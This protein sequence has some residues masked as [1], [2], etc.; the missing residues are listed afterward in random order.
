MKGISSALI[1]AFSVSVISTTLLPQI[2]KTGLPEKVKYLGCFKDS[3]T[4]RILPLSIINNIL[5]G[6]VTFG[7]CHAKCK[8]QYYSYS[9]VQNGNECWCG[10][11]FSLSLPVYQGYEETKYCNKPCNGDALQICGGFLASNVYHDPSVTAVAPPRK[12]KMGLPRNYEYLG[13]AQDKSVRILYRRLSI[14]LHPTVTSCI[15]GCAPYNSTYVGLEYGK[16]C[17]C[18]D[19]IATGTL[20]YTEAEAGGKCNMRCKGDYRDIC[21]GIWAMTIYKKKTY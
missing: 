9:S 19:T 3:L 11:T 1:L 15:T 6:N 2:K 10:N 5:H 20:F 7:I 12:K 17:W 18:S 8:S 14:G 16:E 13:C 21:G 4:Y